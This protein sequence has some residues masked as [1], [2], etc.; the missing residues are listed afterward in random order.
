[1][2]GAQ[3]RAGDPVRALVDSMQERVRPLVSRVVGTA[4][5]RLG[6]EA[7]ANLVADAMRSAVGA[8]AAITNIGGLRSE[9]QPGDITVGHMFELIPFENTLVGVRLS[10]AQLRAVLESRPEEARVSGL[11]ARLDVDAPPGR[12]IVGF[13]DASGRAIDARA[14]YDVVTNNFLAYGGDGF[15]GFLEGNDVRWTSL[16]MRGVVLEWIENQTRAGRHID[17]D[18]EPRI[19]AEVGVPR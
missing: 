16:L 9:F 11:R 17:P 8:D 18:P 1:A 13:E 7:L 10:G 6:R 14:T 4:A 5:R 15:T 12:R 3:L 2:D 19:R